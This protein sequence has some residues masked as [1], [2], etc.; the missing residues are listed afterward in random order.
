MGYHLTIDFETR[1]S[2]GW[3]EI[4]NSISHYG[5]YRYAEACEVMC[6]AVMKNE[7]AARVW[8]APAFRDRVDTEISDSELAGLI[9]NASGI[10][11]HNMEFEWRVWAEQ[12]KDFPPLDISKCYCSAGLAAQYALPR[13]LAGCGK[14]LGLAEA[15]DNAGK[16]LMLK[17][18]K[19]RKPRKAEREANPNWESTL[20]WHETAEQL[21][22]LVGYCRQDVVAEHAIE[23][24]LID[25]TTAKERAVWLLDRRINDR[26]ICIDRDFCA[27]VVDEV[28]DYSEALIDRLV[29]ITD[30]DLDTVSASS[31]KVRK[32]LESRGMVLDNLQSATVD[33]LLENGVED[34]VC[35]EVLEI[36]QSLGK[37][38][39]SKYARMVDLLC[40]DGRAHGTLMYHGCGTGRW[41]GKLI[42][43][44]NFPRG[45]LKPEEVE[46][47]IEAFQ[48]L[49]HEYVGID[50][51]HAASSCLRGAIVAGEGKMLY[52]S[53]F[54]NIEGRI[55]AWLSGED[56][57]VEA[58]KE[59]DQGQGE[60]LYKL[61]Y[62]DAFGVNA[63]D[64]TKEER[65]VGKCMELASGYGGGISAFQTMAGTY[66]VDLEHLADMV[67]PTI[68]GAEQEKS[69][70]VVGKFFEREREMSERAAYACNVLKMRWREKH[71]AI[72]S[73]WANIE[74]ACIQTVKTGKAH[75]YRGL[76]FGLRDGFLLMKLP[77]KRCLAFYDP[78][79]IDGDFGKEQLTFMHVDGKTKQWRRKRTYGGD[80]F[81]S[82]VQAIARDVMCESMLR[83]EEAG[84]EVILTVHDEI[85]SEAANGSIEEYD[86]L[87]AVAP[88]WALDMPIAV[89]G[90]S[91]Y[92][93]KKG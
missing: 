22:Q 57:K 17:M 73:A 44:Q 62:A 78:K 36:R 86:R 16:T 66:R 20:Y 32:Y 71:P 69:E 52:C 68:T 88:E 7:G 6:L 74:H 42:Q 63:A 41:S 72:V 24:A 59:F 55:Q 3:P 75:K 81:Q 37:S 2:L 64:V 29:H 1:C 30:G 40:R 70:F 56:W 27:A 51:L 48:S 80:M 46:D 54:A 76:T 85:L 13:S 15:K 26:G 14:A 23:K 49:G 12:M 21:Q 83:V 45:V 50:P 33:Q 9:A 39:V 84:Y 89:E 93:Y 65:Q 53:D 10:H 28:K 4:K 58:F 5:A 60:C 8:V 92:R 11:A 61:A 35:R 34:P 19:P 87:M 47:A 67:G 18:C 38:S 43:P 90:Y 25:R 31:P 82:A 91:S 77:S 79:V